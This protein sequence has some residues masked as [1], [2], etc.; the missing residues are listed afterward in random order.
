M[1]KVLVAT[2][3]V[4]IIDPFVYQRKTNSYTLTT[5][6]YGAFVWEDSLFVQVGRRDGKY[7][8]ASWR[9]CLCVYSR[10]VDPQR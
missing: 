1:L 9:L 4:R 3:V 8:G 2:G 7:R 6:H 5:L 10:E